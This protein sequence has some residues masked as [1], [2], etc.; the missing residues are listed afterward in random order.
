MNGCK[1]RSRNGTKPD[2]V[3]PRLPS[4]LLTRLQG[5][6]EKKHGFALEVQNILDQHAPNNQ[7]HL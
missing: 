4:V 6:Y 1:V 2:I 5:E 3:C 7:A